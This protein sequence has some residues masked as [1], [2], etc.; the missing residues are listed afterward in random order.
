MLNPGLNFT[1]GVFGESVLECYSPCVYDGVKKKTLI[2][3]VNCRI[4]HKKSYGILTS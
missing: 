2:I 3:P 1:A 4:H